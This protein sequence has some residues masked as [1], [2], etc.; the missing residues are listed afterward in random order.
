MSEG[1][2]VNQ[3]MRE[4]NGFGQLAREYQELDGEVDGGTP[5]FEYGYSPSGNKSLLESVTYPHGEVLAYSYDGIGRASSTTFDSNDMEALSYLGLDTVLDRTLGDDVATQNITLDRFGRVA[6]LVW[7]DDEE[8]PLVHHKTGYDR[9]GN[10][11]WRTNELD[12][13]FDELFHASAETI[14][15]NRYDRL[16]QLTA[17]L[18]GELSKSPGKP[19]WDSV[20]SPTLQRDYNYDGVGNLGTI[21]EDTS[22]TINREHDLQNKLVMHGDET[23]NLTYDD[24]GNL[25]EDDLTNT[26]QYDAWNRL[27]AY[28][29][30]TRYLY[31]ALGRRVKVGM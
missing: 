9:N 18:R 30:T 13:D 23:A 10:V 19:V 31:D 26:Y 1:S 8:T 4:F 17:Y 16:N 29:E 11:L 5:Y 24:L 22:V 3:D 12:H 14:D 28:N 15:L 27:V 20:D 2:I 7:E 6:E 21:V 25:I